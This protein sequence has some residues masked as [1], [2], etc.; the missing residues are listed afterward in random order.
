M[1]TGLIA[2]VVSPSGKRVDGKKRTGGVL[3]GLWDDVAV[4]RSMMDCPHC[5][6]KVSR[7][8]TKCPNCQEWLSGKDKAQDAVGGQGNTSVPPPSL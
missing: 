5:K 7:E 3:G 1:V 2:I 8:A 6:S 4:S